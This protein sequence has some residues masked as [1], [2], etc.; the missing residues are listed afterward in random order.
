MAPAGTG[1]S[2]E[3]SLAEVLERVLAHPSGRYVVELTLNYNG[4]PNES[5]LDDLI[6]ILGHRAPRTLRRIQI[7]DEVSQISW[8]KVGDLGPLWRAVPEL[9]RFGVRAGSFTLGAIQL[10]E[11]RFASFQ[12][13]GLTSH[14]AMSIARAAWPKLAHLEVWVGQAAHGAAGIE[15][16]GPLLDRT[17]LPALRH[18]GL[19]NAQFTDELVERLA[20]SKLVTRLTALD[21]S[22]GVLTDDGAARLVKHRDAFRHL[23]VLDVSESYLSKEAV[24]ALQGIANTLVANHLRTPGEPEDRYPA[25]V[26]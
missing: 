26:E 2:W 15:D 4:D 5:T 16:L 17:D 11:L 13:S 8:Y 1:P 9:R 19:C 7:G 14:D 18:L 22:K 21:L 3:G 24:L 10:P 20:R 23:E 12:T 25:I 6:A